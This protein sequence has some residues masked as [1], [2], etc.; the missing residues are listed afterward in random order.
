MHIDNEIYFITHAD[1]QIDPGVP[2]PRWG[3]SDKGRAR[4]EVF[5]G[6]VME[7]NI[8]EIYCSDEQK[9]VDGAAIMSH[10]IGVDYKVVKELH[11]NDRS[12]TGY[13][14]PAEFEKTADEFFEKPEHS[15]RGWEKA[16]IAQQRIVLAI[17]GILQNRLTEGNIAIVSHGAVGALLLCHLS[18]TPISRAMDQPGPAWFRWWKLLYFQRWNKNTCSRMEKHR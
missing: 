16:S 13:L 5:N 15:I 9:A 2:V 1:V 17:E 12:A 6:I 11:E 18:N 10:C 8:S 14:P 7:S 4:H 3:L